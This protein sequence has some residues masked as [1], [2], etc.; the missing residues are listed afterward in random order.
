MNIEKDTSK[1]SATQNTHIQK[2]LNVDPSWRG[3]YKASG[4]ALTLSGAILVTFLLSI[5]ILHVNLP[6]TPVVVL[7][8]PVKPVF[9]Y[10]LAIIGE[11]LL[12]PAGLG[13]YLALRGVKKNP[14]LLGATLWVIASVIFIIS[15]GQILS[16]YLVSGKYIAAS[17]EAIRSMYLVTA[18]T[19]LDVAN[20][21]GNLALIVFQS[22]SI[23]IGSVVKKAF[24]KRIG[25]LV[26]VSASMTIIGTLGVLVNPIAI[27][28][29]LGLIFT[30]VWQ[31]MLGLQLHKMSR[32]STLME[33]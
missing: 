7:E 21:Y 23:L 11:S 24:S 16:L 20:M 1:L 15:R 12:M 9:L 28:T 33:A 31:V 6:L 17:S 25:N 27:F 32:E 8:A 13:I 22:G 5:F 4:I 14:M 29:L 2:T 3:V 19:V 26:I 30:A 10:L 18:D